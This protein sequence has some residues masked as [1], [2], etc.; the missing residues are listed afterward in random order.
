[1]ELQDEDALAFYLRAVVT[2]HRVRD[3]TVPA[4]AETSANGG[5]AAAGARGG[6]GAGDGD[7]E[8][9]K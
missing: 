8:L 3:S 7:D 1:M 9:K 6:K 4:D 2:F 5:D